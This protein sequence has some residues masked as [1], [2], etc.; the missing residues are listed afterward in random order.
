ME[1]EGYC[2]RGVPRQDLD[3]Y[4]LPTLAVPK[5]RRG[6]RTERRAMETWK[7]LKE[8]QRLTSALRCA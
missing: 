3:G 7:A 1:C 2:R 5:A 6:R 4:T 8:Y